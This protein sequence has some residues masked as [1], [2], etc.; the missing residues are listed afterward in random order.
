MCLMEVTKRDLELLEAAAPANSAIY[1]I[2]GKTA[3]TLYISP[4][5]PALNGMTAEEHRVLSDR[6]AFEFVLPEDRAALADA[7]RRSLTG[8]TALDCYFRV[9]HKTLGSVRVHLGARMCGEMA[10][11][12]LFLAVFAHAPADSGFAALCGNGA[13]GAPELEAFVNNIP[14]GVGVFGLANGEVVH[15]ASNRVLRGLL[16]VPDGGEIIKLART[17]IPAADI[18]K[19]AAAVKGLKNPGETTRLIFRY[20]R[21]QNEAPRWYQITVRAVEYGGGLKFF[22]CFSDV[23]AE[24]EAERAVSQNRRMYEAAAELAQLGVWVYNVREHTITLSDSGANKADCETYSIPTVIKNVPDSIA[25]WVDEKDLEKMTGVYRAIDGGAP[26]ATCEYWYRKRP[27]AKPR[28]ERIFYTTVFDGEGKPQL[29]YGVGMD[30]TAQM[31]ERENYRQSVNTLMNADPDTLAA[32]RYDLTKNVRLGGHTVDPYIGKT[33]RSETA[34]GCFADVAALIPDPAERESYLQKFNRTRLMN[35]FAAGQTRADIEYRRYNEDSSIRWVSSSVN[36][37]RNPDTGSVE[38]VVYGRDVTTRKRD[39]QIFERVTNQEFDYVAILHLKAN[40]IEFVKFNAKLAATYRET[41]W[42]H[43]GEQFDFDKIREFTANSWVDKE[44][45]GFYLNNSDVNVVR[46]HLDANGHYEMSL[47]GHTV[48]NPDETMCRKIQHYYLNDD[49]DTVLIIQTDVTEAWKQQ[50]EEAQ[51]AKAEAKRVQEIIDSVASGICT[52]CMPDRD[53]LTGSSVNLRMFRILGYDPTDSEESRREIETSPQI[54][55]YLR[56]AFL[57]VCSEDRPRI[58]KI[59]HDNYGS[60]HFDTGSYRVIRKDGSLAWVSQELIFREDSPQGRVFYSTYKVMDK[61]IELQNRLERQL[62]EEQE[63]RSRADAAN[64]AKSEFLSRM[65]HD[66]RTPLNG[67]IGMTWLARK[68]QNPP[69]TADC[70]GKID[71]SSKFLLGLINDI[72]DMSKAESNKIELHLEPYPP[73]EFKNYLEAVFLPLCKDKNQKFEFDVYMPEGCV[74]MFDKLRINQVV[75]NLLSNAVKFT[76]EGG[77]ITYHAHSR[78][79]ENGRLAMKIEVQDTG[80]GMSDKFQQV[81]FE[82]FSQESR[83]D[84]SATRGTGLGLAIVKKMVDRMGGRISVASK[85]GAGTTFTVELEIDCVPPQTVSAE[86]AGLTAAKG[87]ASLAG[88]HI[89]LCEDHPLNQEIAVAMLRDKQMQT[90]VAEN[91]R[92]GV[93][94]FKR[95]G[96]G[97]YDAILMDIRMPVMDG[98]EAAREIRAL[99]RPDAKTVPIIAMTADAFTDDV[100]KCFEAGM[101]GHT[102]KPIDPNELYAE[103]EKL[104]PR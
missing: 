24:K 74:P 23:T 63:L 65:S 12:P 82:P 92:R 70:L 55:S 96:A 66:I 35:A 52:L 91:G 84:V 87:A 47:R 6:G 15:F 83:S 20:Y 34:D 76:P 41:L 100:Q 75:F 94:L 98:Y 26:S 5:L 22:S 46:R 44:D 16:N 51:R 1:R 18:K 80:V 95:S 50:Q 28:C 27:G 72:L 38:C 90:E 4:E 57:A 42:K 99:D 10:G 104:M 71:T 64:E 33:I 88:K 102:A 14:V 31:Q 62:R 73:D 101:N 53:H 59:F 56:D 9:V 85:I 21:R 29:A 8:G 86:S 49:K 78:L 67:I 13:V 11:L 68:Q 60:K 7:V 54:A 69:E 17:R 30:V 79:L 40:R 3:E 61:E 2:N 48:A 37:I 97:F 93:E 77:A 36:L 39:E 89:L 81:L 43:P 32:Y 19:M 45:S 103:L 58:K 25:Q